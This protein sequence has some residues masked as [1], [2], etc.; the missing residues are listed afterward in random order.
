MKRACALFAVVF[1]LPFA[2]PLRAEVVGI[3]ELLGLD[4]LYLANEGRLVL[5]CPPDQAPAALAAM[6]PS[7]IERMVLIDSPP[8]LGTTFT[9]M[10]EAFLTPGLGQLLVHFQTDDGLRRVVEGVTSLDEVARVIDL[11]ERM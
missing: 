7:R 10:T 5:F 1:S 6:Q 9:P 4:P 2:L 8:T 3:C 11:T